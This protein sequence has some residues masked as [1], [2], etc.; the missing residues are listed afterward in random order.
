MFY[1]GIILLPCTQAKCIK[2]S[3]S[4]SIPEVL[5]FLFQI[6][7][8]LKNFCVALHVRAHELETVIQQPGES[9]LS[10]S[11][12]QGKEFRVPDLLGAFTNEPSCQLKLSLFYRTLKVEASSLLS[13]S[14][15]FCFIIFVTAKSSAFVRFLS[16]QFSYVSGVLY[17]RMLQV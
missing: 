13:F 14:Y 1:T 2:C 4:N 7:Y 17:H 16:G 15:D 9:L 6:F 10:F 8:H 3:N 11:L 5:D 12:A